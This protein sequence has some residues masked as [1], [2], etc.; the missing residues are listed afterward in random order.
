[1]DYIHYRNLE[2]KEEGPLRGLLEHLP[3]LLDKIM[4]TK[5]I[6]RIF[7]EAFM[8]EFGKMNGMAVGTSTITPQS[9]ISQGG[10]AMCPSLPMSSHSGPN[11]LAAAGIAKLSM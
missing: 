6:L 10:A 2:M 1:M 11:S 8:Y 7:S 4:R 5:V 3:I 9:V